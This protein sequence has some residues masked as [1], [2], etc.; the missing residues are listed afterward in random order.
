MARSLRVRVILGE[1]SLPEEVKTITSSLFQVNFKPP[2]KAELVQDIEEML[3]GI[4]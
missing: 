1:R 4:L 3:E 2:V